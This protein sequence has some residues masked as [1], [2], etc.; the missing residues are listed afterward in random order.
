MKAGTDLLNTLAQNP[1]TP[2]RHGQPQAPTVPRPT[3][4]M[5]TAIGD[6]PG[7]GDDDL[8]ARSPA[9]STVTSE[10]E[11]IPGNEPAGSEASASV[12]N[13]SQPTETQV[14]PVVGTKPQGSESGSWTTD[15]MMAEMRK[16]REEAKRSRLEKNDAIDRLK[17][18]YENKLEE[19]KTATKPLE[20]QAKELADLKAKEADAKKSLGEKLADREG[21]IAEL[22]AEVGR[23]KEAHHR[24]LFSL[25]AELEN[26]RSE[27]NVQNQFY[28]DK[29]KEELD[30]IPDKF[31]DLAQRLSKS[32]DSTRE[33]VDVIR[34]AKDKGMFRDRTTVVSHAVPSVEQGARMSSATQKQE[35]ATQNAKLTPVQKIGEG[36]KGIQS[37]PIF[38]GR[39]R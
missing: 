4:A 17:K 21:K 24:E 20:D 38:R 27:I 6:V 12:S 9:A 26:F 11:V 30:L 31:K 10:E 32:C 16:A 28:E 15:S 22:S 7:S 35:Q 3:S 1:K 19:I 29:L 2:I 18:E 14:E 13:G 34:D 39:G 33:A 23:L 5:P 37:N 25:K 36:L 8:L